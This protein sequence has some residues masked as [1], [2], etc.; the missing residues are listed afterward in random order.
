M[1]RIVLLSGFSGSGKSYVANILK[2]KGWYSL[3]IA[4]ELKN[5]VSRKY[6]IEKKILETQEGKKKIHYTGMSYREILIK[7][8]RETKKQDIN[9][10]TK[11]IVDQIIESNNE[12]VVISD[13]RYPYEYYY[14]KTHCKDYILTSISIKRDIYNSIDDESETSLESFDFDITIHNNSKLLEQLKKFI[15]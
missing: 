14:I 4:D 5:I 7:E 10:F 15:L 6:S 11:K 9:F 13:M 1:K 12:K 2:D 3:A 8:A